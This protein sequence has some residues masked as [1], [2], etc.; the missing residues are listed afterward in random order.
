[1]RA[2]P[3]GFCHICPDCSKPTNLEMSFARA[4]SRRLGGP[5]PRANRIVRPYA[6][7]ASTGLR[8]E[9]GIAGP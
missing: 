5:L 4:P 7:T 9:N 2:L 1:M 6:I 3:P 8:A